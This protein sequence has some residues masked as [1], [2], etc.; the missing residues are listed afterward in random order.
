MTTLTMK[1]GGTSVG[2]AE[3]L[4]QAADIV[5]EFDTTGALSEKHQVRMMGEINKLTAG[6]NGGLLV[7]DY[8]R[9]VK[10]LLSGA[11]DPVIT[12][13]PVGAWTHKLTEKAGLILENQV[14]GSVVFDYYKFS[15]LQMLYE[16]APIAVL[17]TTLV[18][19]GILSMCSFS[20]SPFAFFMRSSP[21]G[22][23]TS[24]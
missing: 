12:K 17:V 10:I 8:E 2:S 4:T 1:F 16:V 3:A 21:F 19:F 13:E 11:S 5:L 22:E 6:S 14:P 18:I 9:T 20:F 15:S 23:P 7:S 24:M